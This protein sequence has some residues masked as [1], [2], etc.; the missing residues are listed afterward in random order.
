MK[1]ANG[2]KKSNRKSEILNLLQ[3]RESISVQELAGLL[4][5]SLAT[6]RRDLD[7]KGQEGLVRRKFGSVEKISSAGE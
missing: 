3:T 2:N 6:T 7:E 4:K 1:R 5:I